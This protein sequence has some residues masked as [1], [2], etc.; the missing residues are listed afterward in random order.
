MKNTFLIF[1]VLFGLIACKKDRFPLKE[2]TSGEMTLGVNKGS[3]NITGDTIIFATL[4]SDGKLSF[5]GK[6]NL[7]E[8][9]SIELIIPNYSGAKTYSIGQGQ[10][11]AAYYPDGRLTN[12]LLGKSGVIIINGTTTN[13][14]GS[15]LIKV[16]CDFRFSV[17]NDDGEDEVVAGIIKAKIKK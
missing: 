15:V 8:G 16:G 4:S 7:D 10:V 11:S 1:L 2:P 14:D 12:P 17:R 13:I 6:R 9:P 5:I 3:Y